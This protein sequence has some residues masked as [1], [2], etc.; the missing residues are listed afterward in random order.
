VAV[1]NEV[2]VGR[3]VRFLQKFLGIKGRQ[4]AP[5]TFAGE[6]NATW[7][8]FHGVENRYLEAW[9]RF[10][11]FF[12]I[13]AGGAGAQGTVRFRNPTGSKVI[14]VFEKILTFNGGAAADNYALQLGPLTTDLANIISFA[15]QRLDPR[16]GIN[17]T[18]VLSQQAAAGLG[19][20]SGN[21]LNWG[22][23]VGA[24]YD[25]IL[26]EDQEITLLPGDVMQIIEGG[27]NQQVTYSVIWRE[28]L[29][30]ESE[31]T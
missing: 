12:Q 31:T 4:P 21:K 1:Y 2:Q 26:F 17:P 23:A 22:M 9:N 14:A 13:A 19:L 16:G 11:Q 20:A 29:M 25:V 18:L 6:L 15:N 28:R 10:A 3:Y 7:S 5:L 8:L 30:E 27:S 24:N